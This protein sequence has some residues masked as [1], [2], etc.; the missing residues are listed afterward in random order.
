MYKPVY[1]DLSILEISK[2]LCMTF[3]IIILN[4]SIG[5]MQNYDTWI[6]I[7]LSWIF[8]LKMFIK[9]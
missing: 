6:Q 1:L 5:A 8:K 4:Q 7:A 3:G 9:T 2:T